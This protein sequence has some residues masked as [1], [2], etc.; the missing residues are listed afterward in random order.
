MHLRSITVVL[1]LWAV[2]SSGTGTSAQ[3]EPTLR[4]VLRSAA[5]YVTAFQKQ[6]SG[7]EAE[8][9]YIQEITSIDG[10]TVLERR[11]T[12][13]DLLLT[14]ASG[15]YVEY[16]DV[17]EVDGEPVRERLDRL[18]RLFRDRSRSGRVQLSYILRAS[19]RYNLG[20]IV[21]NVN[22]PVLALSF[23]DSARQKQFTFKRAAGDRPVLAGASPANTAGTPLFRVSTEMWEIEYQE[24]A[25]KTIIRSPDGSDLPAHGRFWINPATGAVLISEVIVNGREVTGTVTVSY[26][27]EPLMGFLVPVEMRET[28]ASSRERITASALYSWFRAIR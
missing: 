25:T 28:Y 17:F 26:Q 7:L 1:G 21:R 10:A 6:L 18:G 23:L 15:R 5:K 3:A 22:T 27:S 8:E 13:A 9:T 11:T 24:R 4:D 16:R 19:A 2:V 14:R 12:Q 20:E